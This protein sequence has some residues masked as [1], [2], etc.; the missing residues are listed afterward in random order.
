MRTRGSRLTPTW[1]VRHALSWS[2]SSVVLVTC[3]TSDSSS[4]KASDVSACYRVVAWPLVCLTSTPFST[5]FPLTP[6]PQPGFLLSLATV[7]KYAL[8]TEVNGSPV[9]SLEEF[10]EQIA[11][12]PSGKQAS[13]A[14]MTSWRVSLT[15][16][17]TASGVSQS[18]LTSSSGP[19]RHCCA[20]ASQVL[21]GEQ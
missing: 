11:L 17:L 9:N 21:H 10:A 15:S 8:V 5:P 1:T 18:P 3:Q 20:G 6:L 19:W 14:F 7:P 12:I 4:L 13:I 16:P 2:P